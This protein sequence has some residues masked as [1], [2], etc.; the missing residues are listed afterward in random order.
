MGIA[1][2]QVPKAVTVLREGGFDRLVSDPQHALDGATP[3][4]ASRKEAPPPIP[5]LEQEAERRAEQETREQAKS[6]ETNLPAGSERKPGEVFRDINDPCYPELVVIPHGEF[7]RYVS[8]RGRPSPDEWPVEQRVQI[9]YDF[10]VGCYPVTVEEYYHFEKYTGRAMPSRDLAGHGRLPINVSWKDA[11]AYVEWLTK[12]SGQ[13]YRLPSEA[14]WQYAASAG[15]NVTYDIRQA[16]SEIETTEVGSYS[17][18]PWGLYAINGT[19]LEWVEDCW[20]DSYQ[21]AQPSP[22]RERHLEDSLNYAAQRAA[23]VVAAAGNQ[24]T[25]GGSAITRHPWV[26]PVAACD[27]RGRPLGMTNLGSAIG[28]RGLMAPGDAITSLDFGRR[29]DHLERHKRRDAIRDR[30][31]RA[32]LVHL[33]EEQRGDDQDRGD[34]GGCA[35]QCGRAACAGRRCRVPVHGRSCDEVIPWPR[36]RELTGKPGRRGNASLIVSACLASSRKRRSASAT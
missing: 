16:L 19:L 28:R 22:N 14:E 25:V 12:K 27:A 11:Q 1:P 33:P 10:A 24:G 35:T 23:L 21:V 9:A 4:Q 2:D 8:N 30:H 26:I 7:K 6:V 34:A 3:A 31:H 20:N 36:K 32:D 15:T 29:H 13:P 5:P 18:N 17:A